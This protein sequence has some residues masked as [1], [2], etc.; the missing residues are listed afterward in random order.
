MSN[1]FQPHQFAENKQDDQPSKHSSDLTSERRKMAK[2]AFRFAA[3]W[4][5]AVSLFIFSIF[6]V[7]NP[8]FRHV[9]TVLVFSIIGLT[10]VLPLFFLT[11]FSRLIAKLV[12][13]SAPILFVWSYWQLFRLIKIPPSISP[14]EGWVAGFYYIAV[15]GL[16]AVISALIIL[17]MF[18]I[19]LARLRIHQ[20]EFKQMLLKTLT[21]ELITIASLPVVLLIIYYLVYIL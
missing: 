11:T 5:I 21:F 8:S 18:P 16:P 19:A 20:P 10:I 7:F 14:H 1:V 17:L 13:G 4:T 9:N 3:F 2:S 15:Y 12:V 6:L